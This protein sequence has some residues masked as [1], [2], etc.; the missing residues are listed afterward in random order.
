MSLSLDPGSEDYDY[1][2]GDVVRVSKADVQGIWAW[3][4]K[5]GQQLSWQEV[6][7]GHRGLGV[8]EPQIPCW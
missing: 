3:E 4:A 8:D 6:E 1:N 2:C 5:S 7:G